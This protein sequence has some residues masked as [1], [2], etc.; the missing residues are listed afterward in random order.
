MIL[1]LIIP[2]ALYLRSDPQA[3]VRYKVVNLLALAMDKVDQISMADAN[4]LSDYLLPIIVKLHPDHEKDPLV[5][6]GSYDKELHTI[7]L[8]FLNMVVGFLAMGSSKAKIALLK[9]FLHVC[10]FLGKALVEEKEMLMHLTTVLN[11]PDWEL[12]AS[13]FRHVPKFS[14]FLGQ[15]SLVVDSLLPIM[16]EALYDAELFVSH[17]ALKALTSICCFIIAKKNNRHK[18]PISGRIRNGGGLRKEIIEKVAPL[19]LHPAHFI[20]REACKY[21]LKLAEA[22]GPAQSFQRL[23][24]ILKKYTTYPVLVLNEETLSQ[25]LRPCIPLSDYN[26]ALSLYSKTPKADYKQL[27]TVAYFKDLGTSE[28]SDEGALL[29]DMK[30]YFFEDILFDDEDFLSGA[31][32]GAAGGGSSPTSGA[33]MRS[34]WADAGRRA[35]LYAT[36]LEPTADIHHHS[37]SRSGSKRSHLADKQ[38]DIKRL[39]ER[40]KPGDYSSGGRDPPPGAVDV[41]NAAFDIPIYD[42]IEIRNRPNTWYR[43]RVRQCLEEDE[44]VIGTSFFLGNMGNWTKIRRSPKSS[45]LAVRRSPANSKDSLVV[46]PLSLPALRV[47]DLRFSGFTDRFGQELSRQVPQLSSDFKG[48]NAFLLH[49]RRGLFTAGQDH[50]IRFWHLQNLESSRRITR[51]FIGPYST[52]YSRRIENS[53]PVY[54]EQLL[55]HLDASHDQATTSRKARRLP[56]GPMSTAKSHKARITDLKAIEHPMRLLVSADAR[57]VIK[58]WR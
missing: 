47:Y 38:G 30:T 53:T 49:E 26:E 8:T 46:N 45:S 9:N 25:A 1:D 19:L 13:M 56:K 52:R 20:H 39:K 37:I 21:M 36:S 17:E 42:D 50:I 48:I 31:A 33:R 29:R 18:G 32:G 28:E 55:R 54:E 5:Q 2:H 16:T 40:K 27:K 35:K 43:R 51:D 11:E 34:D 41:V 57:G 10:E 23:H 6:I 44:K 58:V 3:I 14:V 4:V 12:R 24:P 7:K 22:L 15:E